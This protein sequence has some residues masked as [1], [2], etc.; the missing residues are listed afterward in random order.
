MLRKRMSRLSVLS[1]AVLAA[2]SAPG[3]IHANTIVADG[4]TLPPPRKRSPLPPFPCRR[5]S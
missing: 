4:I 3:A 5:H 1:S 2:L